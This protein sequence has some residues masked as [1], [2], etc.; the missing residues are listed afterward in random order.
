MSKPNSLI[1][2]ITSLVL[3]F[4]FAISSFAVVGFSNSTAE[5]AEAAVGDDYYFMAYFTGNN[6]TSDGNNVWN[7]PEV[8]MTQATRFAVSSDGVHFSALDKNRPAIVQEGGTQNSRDHFAFKGQDGKYYIL[9]TDADYS[10]NVWSKECNGFVLWRSDDLLTWEEKIIDLHD[11]TGLS[12]KYLNYAWA[13]EIIWDSELNKYLIYFA[14]QSEGV[15]KYQTQMMYYIAATNLW[16]VSTWEYPQ[17]LFDCETACIDGNITY[18]PSDDLYYMFYKNEAGGGICLAKAEY[19]H[20]PYTYYGYLVTSDATGGL[21]GCQVYLKGDHYYLFADRYEK[22]L[23]NFAIYDLGTDLSEIPSGT[24]QV[25]GTSGSPITT[26]EELY[27]FGNL[28]PR[29]GSIIHINKT[30]YEALLDKYTGSTDDDIRYDFTR[31]Y[32]KTDWQWDKYTDT[33]GHTIKL[34]PRAG[35]SNYI[36]IPAGGGYASIGGAFMCIDDDTD[37][38]DMFPDDIYTIDFNF[39]LDVDTTASGTVFTIGTNTYDCLMLFG[40]GDIWYRGTGS[41]SDTF[42]CNTQILEGINYKFCFVSDG[43]TIT[44]YKNGEK[45]GKVTATVD[46]P[47]S[48]TRYAAFGN[49]DAHATQVTGT[50]YDIRFRDYA[51]GAGQVNSEYKPNLAYRYNAG[52]ATYGDRNNVSNVT[53]K[54]QATNYEGAVNNYDV[55]ISCMF[56]PGSSLN[57]SG[58]FCIYEIGPGGTG[59][60]KKYFNL[61]GNGHIFYCW[62]EDGTGHYFDVN[63]SNVFGS[64]LSANTWYHL[65]TVVHWDPINEKYLVM[66]YVNGT[67]TYESTFTVTNYSTDYTVDKYFEQARPV[68]IGGGNAHW[69]RDSCGYLDDLRVYGSKNIDPADLYAEYQEEYSNEGYEEG[70]TAAVKQYV[71]NHLGSYDVVAET[72]ALNTG[73]TERK[74]YHYESVCTGGYSNIL[75]Q[76][77]PSSADASNSTAGST[78]FAGNSKQG[79]N[80]YNLFWP[81]DIALLYDGYHKTGMPVVLE[82]NGSSYMTTLGINQDSGKS[83]EWKFDHYWTGPSSNP[84]WYTNIWRDWPGASYAYTTT[85]T[86]DYP[87]TDNGGSTSVTDSNAHIGYNWGAEYDWGFTPTNGTRF[88]WNQCNYVGSGNTTTYYDYYDTMYARAWQNSERTIPNCTHYTYVVNYKPVFDILKSSSPTAMPN[89]FGGYGIKQFY[90]AFIKGQEDNYTEDSLNQFYVAAYK[91]LTCNPVDYS[92]STYRADFPGTVT[93]AANEIKAAVEEFNKINLVKRAD[94]STLDSAYAS[95]NTTIATLGTNSQ[96]KTTSSIRNLISVVNKSAFEPNDGT[97]DRANL[98]YDDYQEAIDAEADAINS[99][100]TA[101]DTLADLEDFD[102]AYTLGRNTLLALDGKQ[103]QYK[104]AAINN[105]KTALTAG[106]TVTYA[107]SDAET[108]LDY[109]QAVQTAANGYETNIENAI[110]ALS[111]STNENYIDVSAYNPAYNKIT[112]LDKD[113][114]DEESTSISSAKSGAEAAVTYTSAVSYDGST[115]N[116]IDNSV[117]QADVDAA[118]TTMLTALTTS[119]KRYNITATEGVEISSNNGSYEEGKATYGTKMTFD[120]NDAETA[121]Y[122][123]YSSNATTKA[124]QYLGYGERVSTGVL[125]NM[126]VRAVKKTAEAPNKLTINRNYSDNPTTHGITLIT[127]TGSSYTLPAAPAIAYYEFQNYTY[128]GTTY[129]AG[130]TITVTGKNTVVSANYN[131]VSGN[132]YTV[133]ISSTSGDGDLYNTSASYNTKIEKSAPGAYGWVK[134]EGGKE[135]MYYVGSD[136]TYFVYDSI[137]LKAVATKP[138]GYTGIP[139][140]YLRES[141][142]VKSDA[143]NGKTKITLNGNYVTDGYEIVEYGILLGKA[144]A[145]GTITDEDVV[146]ENAGSDVSENYSVLRAKATK[147]VGANQFSIGVTTS[148]TG[149][150]KYRGYVMYKDASD[151]IITVYTDVVNDSI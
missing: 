22:G 117:D 133:K 88:F 150:F 122:M 108:R 11:V 52:T 69:T 38:I 131:K 86:G 8:T 92:E 145:G 118:V 148:M 36:K 71:Y 114:Y 111:T 40:N 112:N 48:G 128:N 73:A 72:N 58:D 54:V 25:D 135:T 109:G 149:A 6:R 24:I 49:S 82:I 70:A 60:D 30:Q 100:I 134:V 56:N 68:Y 46:F 78:A 14:L 39:T 3:S 140:V 104:A 110:A 102:E 87:T 2:K 1:K 84:S 16:D 116:V 127:Y 27:G 33:S 76:K 97:F 19:A 151:N 17:I 95:A 61:M 47:E 89:G 43:T 91:L 44:A 67:R 66:Q 119:V 146:V 51:I 45:I 12:D 31:K 141:G 138:S 57:A 144:K 113:A 20:G 41:D 85:F 139:T 65:T 81:T 143:G 83:P 120:S 37:V 99:K 63:A 9:A 53:T 75:A 98:A 32:M 74:G 62:A 4:V 29:H 136:L 18:S 93:L 7:D 123:S 129:N 142:T 35:S 132:A 64:A 124:E 34:S 121:W 42:M 105:L 130:D 94:F 15:T 28:S 107:N 55:T 5:T 10:D 137:E 125:G 115:I 90:T 80:T 77:T 103:A 126:N 96:A 13:P 101:L 59:G 106:A 147:T 79:D 21:E 23:G 26:I 50:Y